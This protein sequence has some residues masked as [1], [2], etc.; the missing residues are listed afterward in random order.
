MTHVITIDC[1]YIAPE[2]AAAY[3][4]V[5][6]GRGV[7]IENNTARAV[8]GLLQALRDEGLQPSDVEYVIVTHA[9]L[10]HAAG[11]S[12]L[13]E[14][15]PRA[16][17]LCHPRATRH[18]IDPARLVEGT[19]A[20]YGAARFA[21]L[22]GDV[23]PIS[24]HRVRGVHDGE[25]VTWSGGVL[26]FHHTPGHASHHLAVVDPG[27]SSVFTGD[28][29]GVCYPLLQRQ[30][31]LVLPSS[32]PTDFDA[33]LS[34]ASAQRIADLGCRHLYPTHFGQM[35][36]DQQEALKELCA[37]FHLF[38]E[39][40]ER[41]AADLHRGTGVDQ[42]EQECRT[43]VDTYV[44][45]RLHRRGLELTT[46]EWDLLGLDRELN[47]MGLAFAAQRRVRKLARP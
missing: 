44:R 29:F 32:P 47:A 35:P 18:L 36:G 37:G 25:T 46:A 16:E 41:C 2:V 20:V 15:C 26:E 45:E 11:S 42:V 27:S 14:A 3:L 9:H 33:E 24:A 17:L 22:Y 4:L 1:N 43:T 39:C 23:G 5:R 10:D 12:A 6:N 40:V 38:G 30:G 13:M 19:T 31:Q 28:A 8:P 34:I 21:E 7:F